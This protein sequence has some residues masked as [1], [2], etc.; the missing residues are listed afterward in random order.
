MLRIAAVVFVVDAQEPKTAEQYYQRARQK[1]RT[2]PATLGDVEAWRRSIDADLERAVQLSPIDS[3]YRAEW[4]GHLVSS[5]SPK[6]KAVL[7]RLIRQKPSVEL[8]GTRADWYDD[9]NQRQL[10]L[11]DRTNAI[12]LKANSAFL[13]SERAFEYLMLV[14][15]EKALAD[16]NKAVAL[17]PYESERYLRRGEC[18]EFMRRN[19]DAEADYTKA[20]ELDP[21]EGYEGRAKFYWFNGDY[22]KAIS[23]ITKVIELDPK[24]YGALYLR[25]AMYKD[26]KEYDK[27]I[28][29]MSVLIDRRPQSAAYLELRAELYRIVGKN[30]LAAKDEALASELSK[31]E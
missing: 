19:A 16:Y 13:Y 5:H 11:A 21:R 8:Y 4:A 25:Y 17:D 27:A 6:A 26:A 9:Q 20:V 1:M 2:V 23:D 29:D 14:Q 30:D 28:A 12:R 18:Y 3:F 24:S 31:K 7:D 15:Y 22:A 10:A